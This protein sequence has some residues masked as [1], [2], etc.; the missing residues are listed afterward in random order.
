M[1]YELYD[2]GYGFAQQDTDFI[3]ASYTIGWINH[4]LGTQYTPGKR[5]NIWACIEHDIL[6]KER[7]DL[8]RSDLTDLIPSSWRQAAGGTDLADLL[9]ILEGTKDLSEENVEKGTYP[10]DVLACRR[11]LES[12]FHS[13]DNGIEALWALL[14]QEYAV[15]AQEQDD[16]LKPIAQLTLYIPARVFVYLTAEL[17]N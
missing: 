4:A 6:K 5:A 7:Y 13:E 1:L 9:Y 3:N 14:K 17:K 8:R 12:F 2:A 15:R 10:Y 11:A 16:A